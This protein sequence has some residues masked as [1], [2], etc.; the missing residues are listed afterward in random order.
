M[1]CSKVHLPNVKTVY[2]RYFSAALFWPLQKIVFA[3][4]CSEIGGVS[5]IIA[6][7]L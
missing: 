7:S 3:T 5:L 2:W 1:F 4:Q 6:S